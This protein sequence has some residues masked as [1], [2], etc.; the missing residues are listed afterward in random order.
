MSSTDT[1]KAAAT[2][3][4]AK[5]TVAEV[6]S[7]LDVRLNADIKKMLYDNLTI[8][9]VTG[10]VAIKDSKMTL[11]DL[12]LAIDELE[13]TMAL[14]GVYNTQNVKKPTVD[15]KVDI[16]NFDIPKTFK[17]FNT[18]KKLAPIAQFAK[19]KFSTDLKFKTLL[20]E[21]MEP[22]MNTLEGGGHLRTSSVSVEGFEPINKLADALKQE[23]YKKLTFENVNATYTFKDGRVEVEEMPIKTGN[24]TAKVKGSTGFDQTIDYTWNM[25]IPRAEFGSQANAAAGSVLDQINKAAGT[26]VKL[27]DK[28]KIKAIFG[29]TITKPVL[30]TDLFGSGGGDSSPKETAKEV[31]GQGV[32]MAK[33]KAR[34]ESEKIMKDAQ[35]EADKIKADAK[36]LADKTKAE[37]YTAIDKNIEDLKNPIAK[38]SAKMAAPAAKKEV[39]K[40]AQKILDEANKKADDVLIKAKAESDKKLQK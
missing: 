1:T 25:E 38:A 22:V 35:A 11:E 14:T 40:Q 20:D 33:E 16:A 4:T 19:G 3:D 39:D 5:A 24:I 27:A 10:G 2:P 18:V 28:V 37:G 13:G 8:T 9:N 21:H 36:V 26:N 12:K 15:F 23:K 6:P 34:E 32:D 7:N 17:A 30:K 31:I 29:G